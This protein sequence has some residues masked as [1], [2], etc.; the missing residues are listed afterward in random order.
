MLHVEKKKKEEIIGSDFF[1]NTRCVYFHNILRSF[2]FFIKNI[3]NKNLFIYEHAR[4]IQHRYFEL[5]H[6]NIFIF[7]YYQ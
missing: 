2:F 1:F 4:S 7:N 5:F 3:K 6:R